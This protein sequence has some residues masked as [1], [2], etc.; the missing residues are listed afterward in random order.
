MYSFFAP[1]RPY[2]C[3]EVPKHS[4]NNHK[5]VDASDCDTYRH[6][7]TVYF[8]L[9]DSAGGIDFSPKLSL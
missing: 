8:G 4:N 5:S 2:F 1:Q 7:N 9:S 6:Y 3:Y